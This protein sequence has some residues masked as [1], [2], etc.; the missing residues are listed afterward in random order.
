MGMFIPSPT[1]QELI[2]RLDW[3][4]S[5]TNIQTL[6]NRSTAEGDLFHD[7]HRSLHRV[8]WRLDAIPHQ[9]T[10]MTV[11]ELRK[12]WY[13]FLRKGL[14]SSTDKQIKKALRDALKDSRCI[15]VKFH[16]VLDTTAASHHLFVDPATQNPWVEIV[17]DPGNPTNV[18]YSVTL[19]CPNESTDNGAGEHEPPDPDKNPPETNPPQ[20]IGQPEH[21]AVLDVFSGLFANVRTLFGRIRDD[22]LK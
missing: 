5:E 13:A 2:A 10:S 8:A 20:I 7:T 3:A 21:A 16:A 1:D 11:P 17:P 14:P 18:I 4:F 6:R 22:L 19:V 9:P 12:R 15:A